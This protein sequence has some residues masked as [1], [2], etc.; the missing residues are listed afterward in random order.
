MRYRQITGREGFMIRD[1]EDCIFPMGRNSTLVG[2]HSEKR[3]TV[4]SL[5]FKSRIRNHESGITN[6][7]S[8][9]TYDRSPDNL[10]LLRT[11]LQRSGAQR[12]LR[13]LQPVR[14]RRLPQDPLPEVRLRDAP[15]PA[16][17][18][19]TGKV[20]EKENEEKDW[21]NRAENQLTDESPPAPRGC[22]HLSLFVCVPVSRRR[23]HAALAKPKTT[24]SASICAM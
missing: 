11:S 9:S 15:L 23:N 18:R 5:N 12:H 6:P 17:A 22:A 4:I 3:E 7:V 8:G 13:A 2:G 10:C 24:W 16:P 21:T 1:S 14:R 19:G 20:T